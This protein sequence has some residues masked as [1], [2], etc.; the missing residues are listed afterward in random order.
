MNTITQPNDI[1]VFYVKASSFP[2]GI[3]EA[4]E[5]IHA[6][7][8]FPANRK[9]Y[10]ISRPEN[11]SIQ[12]KAAAEELSSGEAEKLN[13]DTLILKKGKYICLTVHDYTK[14][15]QSIG[16]AFQQLLDQPDL[17]PQGYCVE[18]YLNDKDMQCII[19]LEE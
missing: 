10:G 12:Y 16:R 9:F 18:L 17:D 13:C 5:K 3:T 7:A 2:A 1:T 11:G 4:H 15:I 6:L 14:D 19:R 8:P